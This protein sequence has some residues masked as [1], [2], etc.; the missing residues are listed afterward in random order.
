MP[1]NF[2]FEYRK[3]GN[4]AGGS[5]RTPESMPDGPRIPSYR[6]R[7]N[8]VVAAIALVLIIDTTISALC[9]P[10]HSLSATLAACVVGVPLLI[11]PAYLLTQ[12]L[13]SRNWMRWFDSRLKVIAFSVA[14]AFLAPGILFLLNATLDTASAVPTVL[15]ISGKTISHDRH[16]DHYFAT[17]A[18]PQA[19]PFSFSGDNTE[20]IKLSGLAQ[21]NAIKPGIDHALMVT[22]PGF[23]GFPWIVSETVMPPAAI[24]TGSTP[25]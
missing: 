8:P 19:A 11:Y 18:S 3:P 10:L 9:H 2:R 15:T 16:S 7:A 4:T 13:L 12:S 22:K 6:R 24:H 1:M 20:R 17:V 14:L 21:Y 5:F 25:Q 23:L